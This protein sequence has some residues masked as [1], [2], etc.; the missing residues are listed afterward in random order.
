MCTIALVDTHDCAGGGCP[1]A[2]FG[3]RVTF[4]RA[5]GST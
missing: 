1:L 5:K 3:V 2:A 4:V